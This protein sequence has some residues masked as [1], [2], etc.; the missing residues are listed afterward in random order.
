M[1]LSKLRVDTALMAIAQTKGAI[2]NKEMDLFLS[3]TP[4][5]FDDEQV[6]IDWINQRKQAM[7]RVRDRLSQGITVADPASETQVQMFN[8]QMG[9]GGG[10]GLSADDEALLNKYAPQQ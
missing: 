3:P 8:N 6:W 5:N 10:S 4:T 2:S 9:Q 1:L 7:M